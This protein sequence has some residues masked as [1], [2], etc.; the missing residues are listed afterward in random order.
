MNIARITTKGQVTLPK[1]V[2]ERLGAKRGDLLAFELAEGDRM[3]IRT[4]KQKP[5]SALYGAL[6]ATRKH[7]GKEAVRQEVGRA[8]G[9]SL[10]QRKAR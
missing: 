3:V 10:G 4:L 5:L 2:R 1:A 8:V 9:K 6:P 7:P